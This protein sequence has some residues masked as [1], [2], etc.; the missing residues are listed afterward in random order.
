MVYSAKHSA[1]SSEK[2]QPSRS[3]LPAQREAA[4]KGHQHHPGEG[5]QDARGA[6]PAD[7]L[8]QE[9]RGQDGDEHDVAGDQ[10]G[11]HGG[12]DAGQGAEG[13]D[14]VGG[15]AQD[16]QGQRAGDVPSAHAGQQR[17]AARG[18]QVEQ[19]AEKADGQ[20]H[21]SELEGVDGLQDDPAQRVAQGPEQGGQQ[22]RQQQ[23][24][25][26]GFP[27]RLTRSIVRRAGPAPRS[28]CRCPPGGPIRPARAGCPRAARG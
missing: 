17:Q 19:Y 15:E 22:D 14:L 3:M 5:D 9:N 12:G 10:D 6:L 21:A 18:G 8:L 26:T 23:Q 1:A 2:A 27:H 13:E 24:R 20:G 7:A 28:M 4:I 16:A 25:R 11:V